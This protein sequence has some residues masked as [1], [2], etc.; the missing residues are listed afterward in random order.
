MLP[1]QLIAIQQGQQIVIWPSFKHLPP[2]NYAA[3][4]SRAWQITWKHKSL[5]AF[6]LNS[7]ITLSVST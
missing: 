7:S 2:I 4:L 3:I 1:N 6:C 5:R